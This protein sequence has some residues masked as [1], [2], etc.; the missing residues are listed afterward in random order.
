MLHVGGARTALFNHLFA[1]RS[2]GTFVLRIDDTDI[3]RSKK[4]FEETIYEDLKWLGIEWDE[5]PDIGGPAKVYRQAERTEIYNRSIQYLLDKNRAYKD[6]GGAIRLRYLS[7]ETAVEDI[8][9]GKMLF[10]VRSLGPEPVLVRSDGNPTYHLASVSDDIEMGI[11]HVIRGQDHLTNTAKHRLIFEALDAPVPHFAHLPL[12]LGVDGAKLSKRNS[13]GLTLVREFRDNGYL[14]EALRNFLFLL[15]WSH[16]EAK[17]FISMDEAIKVFELERVKKTAS[18]F[19]PRKLHWLNGQWM[20][21]VPAGE[22]A[23]QSQAYLG[24]YR[25]RVLSRG[26]QYWRDVVSLFRDGFQLLTDAKMIAR[27]IF[28]ENLPAS[29]SALALFSSAE[30]KAIL[31]AVDTWWQGAL[32]KLKAEGRETIESEEAFK[33]MTA[34]LKSVV[35]APAKSLFQALRVLMTGEASGPELK[36]LARFVPITLLQSRAKWIAAQGA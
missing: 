16:P 29:E 34:E 7:N 30:D 31:G 1:K 9:V 3:E 5:G 22:I 10:S 8:V 25:E 12:I 6:D 4:E 20:R 26:D 33:T 18:I 23:V 21:E 2:G 27:L 15:G 24:E 11:T 32:A 14:A 17:D 19:E 36:Y 35:N 28:D 13:E